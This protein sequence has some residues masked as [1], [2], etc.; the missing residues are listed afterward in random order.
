ML[1]DWLIIDGNNLVH[2]MPRRAGLPFDVAR[3]D[4]AR[5]IDEVGGVL[6]KRVTLIFDG[7]R[8]GEDDAF[9][10]SSVE[11][12][13]S[14]GHRTADDVIERMVAADAHK[15]DIVVVTSDHAERDTVLAAG[16]SVMS[17][18]RFQDELAVQR[19]SMIRTMRAK[20]RGGATGP[21]LG[22]FFPEVLQVLLVAVCF[23]LVLKP[24]PAW[25]H[26]SVHERIDVVSTQLAEHPKDGALY[27][28]RATLHLEH[29]DAGDALKDL[30]AA[31][32]VGGE[33]SGIP[34]LRAR[35]LAV[36]G[37]RGEALKVLGEH[38]AVH[39]ESVGAYLTR[40]SLHEEATQHKAAALDYARAIE[41]ADLP[42]ADYYLDWARCLSS[43]GETNAAYGVLCQGIQRLPASSV[44]AVAAYKKAVEIGRYKEALQAIDRFLERARRQERWLTEKGDVLRKQGKPDAAKEAYRAAL[45]AISELPQRHQNVVAVRRLKERVR[46]GLSELSA[47]SAAH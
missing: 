23:W 18:A 12:L 24:D 28:L 25:A 39:P 2:Q 9:R 41:H 19:G 37:R 32:K 31:E 11:V 14:P 45:I 4:L 38:L 13:F 47:A 3:T 33:L 16:G 1:A 29:G 6:A 21:S 36:L 43:L 22:D 8:G 26:G 42:K 46:K 34:V 17:C 30:D 15:R 44:L 35:A 10:A 7:T 27:V 5:Q 20:P 40:A